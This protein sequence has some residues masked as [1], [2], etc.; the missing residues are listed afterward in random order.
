[1]PGCFFSHRYDERLMDR[2]YIDVCL[3]YH[4]LHRILQSFHAQLVVSVQRA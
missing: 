4:A 2:D 3:K 1:M